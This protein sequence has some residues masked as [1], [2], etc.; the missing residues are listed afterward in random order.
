M[1]KGKSLV[2]AR[3][4]YQC[5]REPGKGKGVLA[6]F[7]PFRC[8]RNYCVL[9]PCDLLL[10]IAMRY[11]ALPFRFPSQARRCTLRIRNVAIRDSRA[12]S[13]MLANTSTSTGSNMY[14]HLRRTHTRTDPYAQRYKCS[15]WLFWL[16]ILIPCNARVY[17]V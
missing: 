8:V 11:H 16:H 10:P 5:N 6:A 13:S 4:I 15:I 1:E 12:Q 7:V 2:G 17:H 14:L 9:L 3:I